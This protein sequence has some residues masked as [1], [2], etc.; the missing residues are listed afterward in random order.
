MSK[1]VNGQDHFIENWSIAVFSNCDLQFTLQMTNVLSP[2]AA[3]QRAVFKLAKRLTQTA[4]NSRLDPESLRCYLTSLK[5]QYLKD[6]Q[7]TVLSGTE[8]DE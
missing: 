7:S 2:E 3:E 6:L 8:T 1:K 4:Q 5:E